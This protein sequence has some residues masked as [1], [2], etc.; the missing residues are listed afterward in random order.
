MEFITVNLCD[1]VGA[2]E[3]NVSI[4]KKEKPENNNLKNMNALTTHTC[5]LA[6]KIRFMYTWKH[7]GSIC[8]FVYTCGKPWKTAGI[9]ENSFRS[10]VRTK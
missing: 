5:Q 8:V 1:V 9:N 4:K 2:I 10:G 7:I 3:N 6:E